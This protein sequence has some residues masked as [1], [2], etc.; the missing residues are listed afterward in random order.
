MQIRNSY[1][2]YA[3]T[4]ILCWSSAYVFTRLTLQYFSAYSLGFLRYLIA[5]VLLA[6][7]ASATK[8]Q[9][10]AKKDLPLF[11][12][13]GCFGF[14]LYMITYNTGQAIVPASTASFVIATTPVLTAF[15]ARLIF[16]ERLEPHKWAAIVIELAGVA[17]LTLLGKGLSINIGL[18]WLFAAALVTSVYNLLQKKLTRNYSAFQVSTY[19]I[20]FGALMLAIFAPM[21]WKELQAAPPIQCFYVVILGITASAVA[22]VSWAV[23]F[24]KA[25]QISQ[26][27]NYMFIMPILTSVF[28]YVFLNEVPDI[29]TLV[30]GG[31]ILTG[32]YVFNFGGR[33]K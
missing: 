19:C 11:A 5:S 3:L 8:M 17:V 12:A 24:A 20:F 4:T 27:S 10:P 26:V 6:I 25:K 2:P 30:G 29:S 9:L 18:L 22:Y 23:A 31:V 13:G 33:N 28:G 1:H 21:S 7:I 16:K 15:F 14:F 32:V